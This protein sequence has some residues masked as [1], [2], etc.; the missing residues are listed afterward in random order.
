[1]TRAPAS[2]DMSVSSARIRRV[3]EGWK[4][5]AKRTGCKKSARKLFA[6]LLWAAFPSSS[7]SELSR[8]A[9][10]ALGVAPRTVTNWLQCQNDAP[11]TVVFAVLLIAGAEVVF[12]RMEGPK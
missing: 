9:A 6:D 8:I 7:E 1:M 2:G 11:S 4:N 3:H 10:R 12:Q 5:L